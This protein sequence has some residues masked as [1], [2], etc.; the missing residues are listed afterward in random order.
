MTSQTS[1]LYFDFNDITNHCN[2]KQR[3]LKWHYAYDKLSI[4]FNVISYN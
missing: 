1:T 2:S 4:I 3:S